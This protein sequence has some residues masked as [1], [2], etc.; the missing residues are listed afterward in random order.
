M[1]HKSLFDAV[2]DELGLRAIINML[3]GLLVCGVG[4]YITT[5]F[6]EYELVGL[7]VLFFG[8]LILSR[9]TE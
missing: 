7:S 3:P 4:I 1:K 2:L 5:K 8:A 6:Q 9:V